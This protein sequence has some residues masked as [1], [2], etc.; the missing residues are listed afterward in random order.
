MSF[1]ARLI[2][3]LTKPKL[4]NNECIFMPITSRHA[5]NIIINTQYL[6]NFSKDNIVVYSK[7]LDLLSFNTVFVTIFN[8]INGTTI[9]KINIIIVFILLNKKSI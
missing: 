4:T 1:A 6:I 9:T 2:A 8:I 5:R 7:E 3:T